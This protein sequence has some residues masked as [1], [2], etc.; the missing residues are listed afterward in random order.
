MMMLLLVRATR[1]HIPV[2][3]IPQSEKKVVMAR[4]TLKEQ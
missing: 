2:D 3:G 4:F 1:R